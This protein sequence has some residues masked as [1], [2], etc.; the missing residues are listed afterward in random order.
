M[1][2]KRT[3][4]RVCEQCGNDFLA[5]RL[6]VERGG[7]KFCSIPCASEARKSRRP[8]TE[9]FWGSITRGASCWHWTGA[10][11]VQGYGIMRRGADR[12]DREYTHRVAW[13][14]ATGHWPTTEQHVLHTCDS[15]YPVGDT[16][17]RTCLRNDEAGTYILDGIEYERHGHLWLGTMATNMRD[18]VV[19]GRNSPSVE[20][21]RAAPRLSGE[22]APWAR[23]TRAQV[24]EIR[25]LCQQGGL[26]QTEIG[27]RFGVSQS[28]VSLIH[29]D[30]RWVDA[31]F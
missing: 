27:T 28:L 4:P 24:E 20:A 11:T 23:L 17:Y 21:L 16:S 13:R 8:L 29:L 14:L 3:I 31:S 15:L 26:S 22:A 2:Q 19:K 5:Q 25:A 9:R 12:N 7:G 30:Q 18:M 6:Q 10:K 1:Q